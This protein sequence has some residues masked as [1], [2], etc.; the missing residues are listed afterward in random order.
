MNR[1]LPTTAVVPSPMLA[2]VVVTQVSVGS[3]ARQFPGDHPAGTTI[4]VTGLVDPDITKN[5]PVG[6]MLVA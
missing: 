5:V 1:I 3:I 4:V 6:V 2:A